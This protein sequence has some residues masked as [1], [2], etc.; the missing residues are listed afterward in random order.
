MTIDQPLFGFNHVR[1]SF[2]IDT[3][4]FLSVDT[5]SQEVVTTI[6]TEDGKRFM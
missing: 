6:V 5:Q 1:L 3:K 4:V 2:F